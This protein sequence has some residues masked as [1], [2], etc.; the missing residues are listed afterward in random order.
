M[1]E[2][3]R[4]VELRA[5]CRILR[6]EDGRWIAEI[7]VLRG[8]VAYGDTQEKAVSAARRLAAE[9]MQ[10]LEDQAD[11]DSAFERIKRGLEDVAAGRGTERKR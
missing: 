7:P 5:L 3:H 6:E 8:C 9:I 10:D 2:A 1:S 11:D 4:W